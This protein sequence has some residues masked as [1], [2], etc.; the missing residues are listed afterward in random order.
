MVKCHVILFS[1]SFNYSAS[2]V[3]YLLE[4]LH[5]IGGDTLIDTVMVIY[6]RQHKSLYDHFCGSLI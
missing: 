4:L 2:H 5:S 3:L 1:Q 6:L